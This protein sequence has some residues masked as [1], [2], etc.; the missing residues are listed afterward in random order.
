[1]VILL[2]FFFV[3][4]VLQLVG[5]AAIFPFMN[6][7]TDPS[8]VHSDPLL[9]FFYNM[10][11]FTNI[12]SFI[13]ASGIAMFVLLIFSNALAAFTIW[14]K[15]KYVMG[16]NHNLSRRLLGLYLS[17]PYTFF[18]TRSSSDLGSNILYEV[19]QLTQQLLLPLF[20]LVI[21]S[22]IVLAMVVFLLFTDVVTTL[23]AFSIVGGAYV[24][25]NYTARKK[26]KKAGN[27]RLAANKGRFASTGEAI[28]GIKVTKVL[29]REGYFLESFTHYSERF[30]KVESYI[31]VV[32]DLPKFIL[33]AIAFGGVVMLVVVMTLRTDNVLS[34][35]PFVTLFA[36]AGYK[37]MPALQT[38]YRSVVSV[39]FNQAIVDTLYQ[40]MVATEESEYSFLEEKERTRLPFNREVR[41]DHIDFSY[42]RS[43]IPTL[44]EITLTIPKNSSIGFVGSTGS[45]K[46]TLIDLIL[47]LLE[48]KHGTIFVDDTPLTLEN[49]RSWQANIGY[50][51]QD[52]YLTDNSIARNIAFGIGED[53][54]DMDRV[55]QAARIAAL[56]RFVDEELPH[57]FHT[58]VGERG[59][60]LS[61]GQ[62]QR[63]GLARALYDNP[64]IL[65][66]DEA[67]SALDGT[68]E[69]AV[70]EAIQAASTNRTMIM[71][72][73]RISTVKDCDVIYLLDKG[74]VSDFGTY[75][76]LIEK[77]PTFRKMA[78]I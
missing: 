64:E 21:Q 4:S 44:K 9:S 41:L 30:I 31:N 22:L 61:G 42:N 18:L 49:V 23:I 35:L 68:T 69:R 25:T 15:T 39:Y 77:N 32:R 47:G 10:F 2:V 43:E 7:V 56:E 1:M 12:K 38:I 17:R 50:V 3:S 78:R 62:R 24:I 5:V 6:V 20:D 65:I 54:L 40:E 53:Q 19:N 75:A 37:M 28:S 57:G 14:L 33:E 27:E 8:S 26:T 71:I 70:M 46:T 73:H 51:P 13:V 72:A 59:I 66:L 16:L 34:I 29:G 76:E 55:R 58:I 67:T 48:P 74:E 11:H 63:I 36:F 60:R 52:I 45:G